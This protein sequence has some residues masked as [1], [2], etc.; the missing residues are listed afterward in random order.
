MAAFS[1]KPKPSTGV[2]SWRSIIECIE[3]AKLSEKVLKERL[4]SKAVRMRVAEGLILY[5][6]LQMCARKHGRGQ[7]LE[8]TLRLADKFKLSWRQAA[9]LYVLLGRIKSQLN[10]D[11][12][13]A[14]I[15]KTTGLQKE[16]K[17][18]AGSVHR[19]AVFQQKN[20]DRSRQA[21]KDVAQ[22]GEAWAREQ[23]AEMLTTHGFLQG[24]SLRLGHLFGVDDFGSTSV[25][26]HW[27]ALAPIIDKLLS[28][29]I[30]EL[31]AG[32]GVPSKK[33]PL[34]PRT[35]LV[36]KRLPALYEIVTGR[37]FG[38]SRVQIIFERNDEVHDRSILQNK[39]GMLF[40]SMAMEALGLDRPSLE[41]IKSNVTRYK[42]KHR[43]QV[44]REQN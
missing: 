15:P 25:V 29:S 30:G 28:N 31:R 11:N 16:L 4:S 22:S 41:T 10:L 39:N 44:H 34:L 35:E 23:N 19:I 26:E 2:T 6:R 9:K 42:R 20:S 17:S 37:R 36:G 18:I 40:V 14:D 33:D 27:F 38:A 5:H 12:I 7:S 8:A 13:F 43:P 21:M 24:P 32:Q 1:Q 3:I